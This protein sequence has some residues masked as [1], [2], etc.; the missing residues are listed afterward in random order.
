M[1]LALLRAVRPRQWVKNV[2]VG[3]P[4]L[5]AHKLTDGKAAER[6]A[7][8]VAIFCLLSSA[9][10]LW[11]DLVDVEKDR[12]HPKKRA[13]PIASGALPV[14]VA[15]MAAIGFAMAG[16]GCAFALDRWF[17]VAAGGY[18]VLNVAYSLALKKVAYLDVLVIA[19][20]FLLRVI[21]GAL[22]VRVVASPWLLVCTGLLASFLGFGKRAHELA[23]SGERGAEQRAA[24]SAYRLSR[25]RFA[26]WITGISTVAAYFLYTV[27]EHTRTFFHTERMV[28]TA[29]CI[30]VGIT[31]YLFFVGSRGKTESPTEEMLRDPLFMLNLVV[32]AALVVG[33]IYA[34]RA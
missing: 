7:C 26:L 5:F 30:A 17:A 19:A 18:L 32:Y 29:P 11:N 8:A 6:A 31:R 33:I 25:L 15:R 27:A 3:A 13:R 22:A 4:V 10:Y 1:I 2:F 9:V 12:A 23:T 28:W 20:G 21:A 16:L 14:P 34:S 24:L